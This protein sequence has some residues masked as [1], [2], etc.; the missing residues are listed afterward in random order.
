MKYELAICVR[1]VKKY[2]NTC[3]MIIKSG[4]KI[5]VENTYDKEDPYDNVDVSDDKRAGRMLNGKLIVNYVIMGL[6][7]KSKGSLYE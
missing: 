3:L 5:Y 1:S 4:D 7:K 2:K 6:T